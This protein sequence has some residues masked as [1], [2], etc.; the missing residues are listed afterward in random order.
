MRKKTGKTKDKQNCPAEERKRVWDQRLPTNCFN[1]IQISLVQLVYEV[2]LTGRAIYRLGRLATRFG[3]GCSSAKRSCLLFGIHPTLS[4]GVWSYL[5]TYFCSLLRLTKWSTIWQVQSRPVFPKIIVES[6]SGQHSQYETPRREQSEIASRTASEE[7]LDVES[8]IPTVQ[9]D[10]L[11]RDIQFFA[12]LW[13]LGSI[14]IE[15]L[16]VSMHNYIIQFLVSVNTCANGP[17]NLNKKTWNSHLTLNGICRIRHNSSARRR[18]CC[19]RPYFPR[20][21]TS[22]YSFQMKL[23]EHQWRTTN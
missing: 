18:K 8:A 20:D 6:P 3:S 16:C 10:Y 17:K 9:K 14:W 4:F 15:V 23:N 7:N 21:K 1:D 5:S 13:C 22:S 12:F 19:D 2:L 11:G